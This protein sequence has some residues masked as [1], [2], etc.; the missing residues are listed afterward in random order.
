MPE[1]LGEAGAHDVRLLGGGVDDELAQPRVPLRDHAAALE[2]AHDL[3]RGAQ[4]A[5]DGDG[6]LGLDGLE[7]HVDVGGE[8]E[9][10]APV[11]VHQRRAGLA[12]LQHVGD[13][14]QRIEVELDLGRPGPRPRPASG[15]THMATSSPT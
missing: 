6:G 7:V 14:G 12:R 5:R 4:L 2:R 9:V 3:A 15:A 8:E 1:A 13:D 10:V 11:L